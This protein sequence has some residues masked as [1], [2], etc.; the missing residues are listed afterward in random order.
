MNFIFNLAYRE[1]RAS[2]HRLL[3]FFICIAMGVGSIVALRS[4]VQNLKTALVGDARSLMTADVQASSNAA[5][6][7]RVS[8]ARP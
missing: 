6:P 2:W 8:R 7:A 4:L 1:M 3:F 5:C